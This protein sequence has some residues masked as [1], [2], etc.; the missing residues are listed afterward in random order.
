VP[1]N[2]ISAASQLDRGIYRRQEKFTGANPLRKLMD[3]DRSTFPPSSW[4]A[5]LQQE[6]AQSWR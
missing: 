2:S 4:A 3:G 1:E 6:Q 5:A